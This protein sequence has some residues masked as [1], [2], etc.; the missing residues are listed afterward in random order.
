[1]TSSLR[2]GWSCYC[3]PF[4]RQKPRQKGH[5]LNLQYTNGQ[6]SQDEAKGQ[7][8][9]GPLSSQVAGLRH[10]VWQ[11]KPKAT[12]DTHQYAFNLGVLLGQA[13]PH[14]SGWAVPREGRQAKAPSVARVPLLRCGLAL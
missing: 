4:T 10:R 12:L 2:Q 6:Q 13:A 7:A 3:P 8:G 1:M 14:L 9:E 5:C 11:R